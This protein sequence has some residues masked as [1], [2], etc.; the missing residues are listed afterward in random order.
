[1]PKAK[2]LAPAVSADD[3]VPRRVPPLAAT[4]Q[5][6]VTASDELISLGFKLEP[7]FIRDF[8]QGALDNG[9]KLN[10]FLIYLFREFGKSKNR[11]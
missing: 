4:R 7:A 8:K 10:E 9:M 3:I 6:G 1:M 2:T 11:E 5:R